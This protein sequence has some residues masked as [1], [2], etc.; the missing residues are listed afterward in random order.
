MYTAQ[1]NV[2]FLSPSTYFNFHLVGGQLT[3]CDV[4]I[5]ICTL[6]LL[7]LEGNGAETKKFFLKSN[8]AKCLINLAWHFWE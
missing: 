7:R 8:G 1:K 6:G 2:W 5:K 4:C 3:L